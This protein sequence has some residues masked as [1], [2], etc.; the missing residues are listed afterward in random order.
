[1][2]NEDRLCAGADGPRLLPGVDYDVEE[3]GA[4]MAIENMQAINQLN[5][6]A[7]EAAAAAAVN[8]A[9]ARPSAGG[10]GL[11]ARAARGRARCWRRRELCHACTVKRKRASSGCSA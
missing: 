8:E 5:S 6:E 9:S 2:I 7:H 3:G 1:M 11:R 4:E 10:G